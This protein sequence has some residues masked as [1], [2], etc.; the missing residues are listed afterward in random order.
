MTSPDSMMGRMSMPST[1][2]QSC[3]DMI[4]S[5]LVHQ[6]PRQVSGSPSSGV[7]PAPAGAVVEIK[8]CSTVRPSRK[9]R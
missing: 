4:T 6:A 9:S 1:V 2:V 7:S 3:S 5:W 8:Y